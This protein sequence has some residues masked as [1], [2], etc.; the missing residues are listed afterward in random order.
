MSPIEELMYYLGFIFGGTFGIFGLIG[1]A[2]A[3][4]Y[5]PKNPDYAGS[6]VSFL[7]GF[8]L[9]SIAIACYNTMFPSKKD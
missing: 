9:I 6:A 7:V 5:D 2:V 8:A 1:S 3:I 4:G